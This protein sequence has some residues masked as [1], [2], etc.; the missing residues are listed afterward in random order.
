MSARLSLTRYGVLRNDSASGAFILRALPVSLTQAII[1]LGSSRTI[2]GVL[3]PRRA[4]SRTPKSAA[5][6]AAASFEAATAPAYFVFRRSLHAFET[7]A[8][9]GPAMWTYARR[10]SA[11][12]R[13]RCLKWELRRS[14][15][16]TRPASA[17]SARMVR[18]RRP[19]YPACGLEM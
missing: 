7:A 17:V 12:L 11:R 13:A 10:N 1:S 6:N 15:K 3:Q 9:T 4:P 19:A 16:C 5:R 14:L 18:F 8:M 2:I